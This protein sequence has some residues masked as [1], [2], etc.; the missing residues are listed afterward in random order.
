[1]HQNGTMPKQT[2]KT[3]N[4]ST[5][6]MRAVYSE[7]TLYFICMKLNKKTI[8]REMQTLKMHIQVAKMHILNLSCLTYRYFVVHIHI[9]IKHHLISYYIR[10]VCKFERMNIVQMNE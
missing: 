7:N 2:T 6:Y 8:E 9:F 5:L 3:T 4:D 1:M 10:L